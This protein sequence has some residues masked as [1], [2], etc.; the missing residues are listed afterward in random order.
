MGCLEDR[1]GGA[2]LNF[3]R[4]VR[5]DRIRHKVL[6]EQMKAVLGW[7]WQPVCPFHWHRQ[8]LYKRP[9]NAHHFLVKRG[10]VQGWQPPEQRELVDH[11][12]NIIMICSECDAEHERTSYFTEFCVDH[13]LRLGYNLL[14]WI[15]SLPFKLEPHTRRYVLDG[16]R[17]HQQTSSGNVVT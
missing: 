16:I 6:Q 2:H 10:H 3:D 1:K 14:E 11:V 13:K 9:T 4:K 8:E 5:Y 12:A 15:D 7:G 17:K